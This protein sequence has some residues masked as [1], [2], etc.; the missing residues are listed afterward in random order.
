MNQRTQNS[1]RE[2]VTPL[3]AVCLG[4]ILLGLIAYSTVYSAVPENHAPV[5]KNVYAQQ[6]PGT[7]L[8]D[9]TYDV[10]DADGDS[11]EIII[12][13]SDDNGKTYTIIPKSLTG[14]V[15][16]NI[17]PGRGKKIVWDVGKD[18][19]NT[20]GENFKVRVIADD[21]TYFTGKDGAEMALIPAGEFLMGS[22]DGDSDEKPVHTV[23]LDAYYIDA[24]EVTNAQYAKFLNEYGKN[25]D[26]A[27]HELLDI[28]S[29][30]CLIEKVGNTYKPKAGYENH[31]VIEVSWYGAAAYAQFYGK[32]LPTEA[33]WEKSARGGLVGK[34]YPWGDNITHDDANYWET[35]GVDKWD[36]TSPVGSFAPNGYGL[37]DMAG[38]VWEWCAD[39]YD[40]GYYSKSPKNNPKGPGVAITFKNNDF[41]NVTTTRVLRGGSWY[42]LTFILRCAYRSNVVPSLSNFLIGFRCAQDP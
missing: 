39:E 11:L 10:E 15:G 3:A 21:T 36:R 8:V 32:R 6:R 33:E 26:A 38:N 27:G 34:K 14:D 2:G 42:Y 29:G 23:Y 37:Y 35:G 12:E 28:A 18:L 5:V 40:S 25:E 17:T 30:D 20:K 7:R 9:I 31:P 41:T 13:A 1:V 24:Y 22:N 4:I 19:P 16:E